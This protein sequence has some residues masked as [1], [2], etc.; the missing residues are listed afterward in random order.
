VPLAPTR[1]RGRFSSL[2]FYEVVCIVLFCNETVQHRPNVQQRA[3][4]AP[5]SLQIW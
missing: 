1:R 2:F 5:T 3:C 4:C